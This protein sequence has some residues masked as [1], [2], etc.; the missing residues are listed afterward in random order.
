MTIVWGPRVSKRG[1][2]LKQSS[3]F[4][5][6]EVL[7]FD[8]Y[9]CP[10]AR[11][12]SQ[13]TQHLDACI[14]PQAPLLIILP[15]EKLMECFRESINAWPWKS[16]SLN[17]LSS[18]WITDQ[19]AA[20]CSCTLAGASTCMPSEQ[21]FIATPPYAVTGHIIKSPGWGLQRARAR[22]GIELISKEP[23]R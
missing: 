6:T 1:E 22:Q 15:L 4:Q 8:S 12:T 13:D 2:S 18:P 11:H 14:S 23:L 10:Q 7:G 5:R 9:H 16:T 19:T 21:W 20:L 17:K 3:S